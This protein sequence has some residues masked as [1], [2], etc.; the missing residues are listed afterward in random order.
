MNATDISDNKHAFEAAFWGNCANTLGEEIKQLVYAK[1]MG[2]QFS[3]DWRSDF[4][5][6][7]R[8]ATVVDIGGGPVSLLLKCIN[9]HGTVVDP[10]EYPR[11]VYARYAAVNINYIQMR[12]EDLAPGPGCGPFDEVW[13]YNCLQHVDDPEKIIRNARAMATTVRVFE[14]IDI[15]AHEGHPHEL[16]EGFLA[17]ALGAP[18]Q[19]EVLNESGCFGRC[20]FGVFQGN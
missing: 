18:G 20:F 1:R 16:A 19:T 7:M 3:G 12:G 6:D 17:A 5:I 9:V 2:L 15:P 4:N 10:L 8:G 14:W 11:W 13:I